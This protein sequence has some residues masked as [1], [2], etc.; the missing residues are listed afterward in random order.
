MKNL[1]VLLLLGAVFT[2]STELGVDSNNSVLT[3]LLADSNIQQL[4]SKYN[5][6]LYVAKAKYCEDNDCE[7]LFTGL[8]TEVEIRVHK[9]EDLFMRRIPDYLEIIDLRPGY[10]KAA[11]HGREISYPI[12]IKE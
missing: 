2:N 1:I 11:I 4:L 10:L 7:N 9:K 6:I 5:N 8:P 3:K 12:E